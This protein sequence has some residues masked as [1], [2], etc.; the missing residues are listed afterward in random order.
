MTFDGTYLAWV[1]KKGPAYGKAEVTLDTGTP[2]IVDL[3]SAADQ[4]KKTVYNTGL[5]TT[6]VHTLTIKW[7]GTKNPAAKGT[8]IDI[9]A[10]DVIAAP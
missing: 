7:L 5:L 6:G 8:Y 10:F 1:A 9:D 4:Y 2:V 3:Y